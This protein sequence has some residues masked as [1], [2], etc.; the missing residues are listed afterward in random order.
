MWSEE[1]FPFQ[2]VTSAICNKKCFAITW[3]IAATANCEE[4]NLHVMN[5]KVKVAMCLI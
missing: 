3:L 5:F 4:A 2:S 1:N